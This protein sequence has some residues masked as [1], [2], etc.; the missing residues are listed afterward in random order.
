MVSGAHAGGLPDTGSV[1]TPP[2]PDPETDTRKDAVQDFFHQ[3][4]KSWQERYA[5][6][7]FE[8]VSY[9]DRTRVALDLLRRHGP[10]S[11]FVLDAGCGAGLQA[12]A[13]QAAGYRVVACDIAQ[14]MVR[15][16]QTNLTA[17]G[18]RALVADVDAAP[19]R[20]AVF[21]VVVALGVIGYAKDWD[22][23][24]ASVHRVLKPGG[25][26]VIS[27]AS[28]QL[29][30]R[31]VSDVVSA[32]PDRAYTWLKRVMTRQPP[33]AAANDP[34][35]YKQHYTYTTA[36]EFDAFLKRHG[37]DKRGS[38]GVNYGQLHFMGKRLFPERVDVALT[39]T[40]ERLARAAPLRVLQGQA[41]IYVT[42]LK[43]P[44]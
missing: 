34:G 32:V 1:V 15:L 13:I 28:E 6:R 39:H 10:G 37:F 44:G 31:N 42:A 27:M 33:P 14:D 41:R 35:F 7:D 8:S 18:G 22:R 4:A 30:L 3:T 38:A 19:F 20:D 12:V 23:W 40:V 21:D 24:M 9:Q 5:R 25:L 17:A 16:A 29:L 26:L 43:K 11:G 36:R 2:V